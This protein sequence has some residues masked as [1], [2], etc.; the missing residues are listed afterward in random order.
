[1]GLKFR[2]ALFAAGAF[3]ILVGA[4][5]LIA[6]LASSAPDPGV[7]EAFSRG[8]DTIFLALFS[9][10]LIGIG[11]ALVGSGAVLQTAGNR[12]HIIISALSSVLFLSLSA[13]A[14]F[15]RNGSPL[16]SLVSFFACITASGAFLAAALWYA[17]SVA[18]RKFL[19]SIK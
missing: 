10:V 13:V 15:S 8:F 18:A 9:G 2:H 17:L 14:V 11:I 16:F 4:A 5:A 19:L 6:N 3:L 12:P 7:L 1:M